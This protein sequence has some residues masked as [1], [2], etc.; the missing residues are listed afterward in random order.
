[1]EAHQMKIEVSAKPEESKKGKRLGVNRGYR[2][3]VIEEV[4]A[5]INSLNVDS[6]TR[7]E[8]I[9][10]ANKYPLDA[11][12]RFREN[13]NMHIKSIRKKLIQEE[14]KNNEPS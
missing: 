14:L 9:K 7:R 5:W 8:L 11:M 3:P 6:D 13:I 10:K 4:H 2:L 12:Y 1:M